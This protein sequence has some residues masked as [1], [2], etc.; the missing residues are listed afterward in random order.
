MKRAQGR[1]PQIVDTNVPVV[2]NRSHG[3]S[4]ACS[5]NCVQALMQ[6]RSDGLLLLDDH[7]LILKEYRGNLSLSGQPGFGDVFIKWVHDN[8]GRRDLIQLVPITPLDG[9]P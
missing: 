6:L 4:Y 7:G 5:N 3:E 8:I 1:F 2:A 9:S